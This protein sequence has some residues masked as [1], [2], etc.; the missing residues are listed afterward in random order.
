M[1]SSS[2]LLAD[3]LKSINLWRVW[4]FLGLQDLK[5]RYRRSFIGPAW[6]LL[7]LAFFVGSVGAVYGLLFG[8][9][10]SEFL[11]YLTVGFIVWG[12]IV[13]SL[14]EASMTFVNAEGYIKQFS[15]PK[16][17]Y[18]FRSL[19]SYGCNLLIGL[20]VLIPIQLYFGSFSIERWLM[21]L[22]GLVLLF[23]AVLGHIVIVAYLGARFRDLPHAL[24]SLLQLLFFVTPIMFPV[25]IL[26]EKHLDFVY[27][28]N[29][30]HYLIE[31][32]RLPILQGGWASTDSYIYTGIYILIVW[33]LAVITA[34]RLDSKV[35]F[36]L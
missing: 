22:P 12:F 19:V 35:V 29:P 32:V 1:T 7:N 30:L 23:L 17:L 13:S 14:T 33:L 3:S 6:L 25:K 2:K 36:F 26:Q 34:K 15:Y 21:A 18:L 8:Q 28:F 9:S 31:V 11:P 24:G 20:L 10:M 5:A 16:Q 27:Q 4:Y